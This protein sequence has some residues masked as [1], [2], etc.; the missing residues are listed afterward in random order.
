M[1][2]VDP[3][4]AIVVTAFAIVAVMLAVA[5]R[6]RQ[7]AK[8]RI[9]QL[10]DADRIE[11]EIVSQGRLAALVLAGVLP[12]VFGTPFVAMALGEWGRA[13]ALEFVISLMVLS[14]VVIVLPLVLRPGFVRIGQ[15]VLERG[16]LRIE[17]GATREEI[18]L[19]RAWDLREGV[20]PPG[21]STEMVVLVAQGDA[22][23]TL[24][25]PLLLGDEAF[26]E[27]APVV[28][29]SGVLLGPE[30]RALHERLRAAAAT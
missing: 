15:V 24:R 25:Y 9:A 7:A 1:P 13:H 12:I 29:P 10:R 17:S 18:V 2:E 22:R 30:A 5:W 19:T 21:R 14:S 16:A 11:I 23:I 6:Q 4:L 27:G 26:A 3:G 8:A 28:A 20:V